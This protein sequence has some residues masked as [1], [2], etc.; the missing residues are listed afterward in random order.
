MAKISQTAADRLKRYIAEHGTEDRQAI[1][2]YANALVSHYGQASGALACDMYEATAAAQGAAIQSAQTAPLPD[3]NEVAKAVNGT[4]KSSQTPNAIG[5]LVKRT[6]A[7]TTLLNAQRDGAQF[8]WVPH[9]DTCAFCLALASRGWQYM[10]KKAL[11]NGHA[12]HI[13]ANCDCQYAVR[14][15]KKSTVAGYNPEKYREIYESAEGSTP[16]EKINSLRREQYA[17]EKAAARQTIQKFNPLPADKVVNVLR[18]S[19][20]AWINSLSDTEIKAIQKYTYNSGDKK[21]KRFFEQLNAMLR[22]DIPENEK[23]QEYADIISGAI[24]KNKLE[25][26]VIAY[27]RLDK[28]IY[29][30]IIPG[31][32]LSELQFIS[33][34]VNRKGT[35]AKPY[36]VIIRIP[37]GSRAAYIEGISNYPKQR[38]L[39]LDK[40]NLFSVI[41]KQDDMI[42]LEVIP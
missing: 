29:S 3:Y 14:F 30:G 15:D 23:M 28:D 32:V 16:Q 42:E 9:G 22:G 2:E 7:D 35:M 13:H 18:E 27:R 19:S 33:T 12:E 10:S 25:Y 6:G 21:P 38:E 8:A 4:L 36:E 5:R 41:S 26:D 40:D 37:K 39:L 24:K 31:D 11:K 17:A 34:S 1:I 20:E